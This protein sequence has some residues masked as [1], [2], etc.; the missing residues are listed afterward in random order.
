MID[1]KISLTMNDLIFIILDSSY[2]SFS[3]LLIL[4]KI[5][6][7]F[8]PIPLSFSTIKSELSKLIITVTSWRNG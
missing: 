8:P 3:L 7:H 6:Q 5:P 4:L 2:I 1:F